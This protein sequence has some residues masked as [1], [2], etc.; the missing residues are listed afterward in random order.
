MTTQKNMLINA[1][2]C[3][4]CQLCALVCSLVKEG[5]CNPAKARIYSEVYLVEGLRFPRV[6]IN[7]RLPAC[8]EVCPNG[9]LSKDE[10]SGYVLLDKEKCTSC[11]L[12]IDACPYGAI[13]VTPDKAI[14]KCDL[15][16]G[17][18][19]C[20]KVCETHAI[21]FDGREAQQLTK[22]RKGLTSYTKELIK[23]S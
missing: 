18:P 3:T 5:E 16:G 23:E 4:G 11:E 15:C 10:I 22:A 21:R 7:C 17:D 14:I 8:V 9:A 19:E 20:V 6:C 2:V 12:C 13:R 1:S